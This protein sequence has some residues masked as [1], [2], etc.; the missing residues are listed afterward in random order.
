MVHHFWPFLLTRTCKFQK[1]WKVASESLSEA[2][3]DQQMSGERGKIE[4]TDP[5]PQNL[6]T[7]Q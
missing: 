6:A 2:K 7:V 1:I 3:K 5:T 4:K